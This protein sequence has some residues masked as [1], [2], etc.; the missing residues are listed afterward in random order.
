MKVKLMKFTWVC[1]CDFL[2]SYLPLI[3]IRNNYF[4]KN[5]PNKWLF[6][7]HILIKRYHVY[8]NPTIQI[9]SLYTGYLNTIMWKLKLINQCKISCVKL[10]ALIKFSSHS[11]Y[12]TCTRVMNI[13]RIMQSVPCHILNLYRKCITLYFYLKFCMKCWCLSLK[14]CV[15]QKSEYDEV[16]Y[17]Y[18]FNLVWALN[19]VSQCNTYDMYLT[20]CD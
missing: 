2:K 3:K 18:L 10:K 20:M 8:K 16:W 5:R 13:Y 15:Q 1:T 12:N 17:V 4:S 19:E 7:F 14:D 6:L 9:W 11:S